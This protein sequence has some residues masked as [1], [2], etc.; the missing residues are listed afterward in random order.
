MHAVAVHQRAEPQRCSR[1][2]DGVVPDAAGADGGHSRRCLPARRRFTMQ[3]VL[4]CWWSSAC[5]QY[6]MHGP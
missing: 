5:I 4:P 1:M 2:V 6:C 3:V